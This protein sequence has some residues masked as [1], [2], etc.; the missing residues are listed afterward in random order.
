[1]KLVT[2]RV[3]MFQNIIDSREVAIE[4]DVTCLVGKNES[5]TSSI[6]QSTAQSYG[7]YTGHVGTGSYDARVAMTATL[8]MSDT[9]VALR[10]LYADLRRMIDRDSEQ[11]VQGIAVPVLDAVVAAGRQHLDPSDPVAQVVRDFI[12]PETIEEREPMR[13]VDAYLVVRQLLKALD[14]AYASQPWYRGIFKRKYPDP[15][16]TCPGSPQ[17]R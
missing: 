13:A 12:S 8:D 5:P 11:E 9:I 7:R 15:S 2:A 10:R 16:H 6:A 4:G 1:V 3:R 14:R 17:R